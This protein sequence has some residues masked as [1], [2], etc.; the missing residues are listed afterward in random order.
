MAV[1]PLLGPVMGGQNTRP[2]QAIPMVLLFGGLALALVWLG[3]GSMLARRWARALNLVLSWLW[4]IVG[5][6]SL[7]FVALFARQFQQAIGQGQKVPAEVLLVVQL[8][9]GATLGCVYFV[10]PLAMVLFYGG[11][12]VRATCEFKDPRP[13]WTD[14][15]PLPVLAV[16][17]VL[18]AWA[19]SMSWAIP[20]HAM[21]PLFGHLLTGVAGLSAIL[22]MM[23]LLGLLAWAT[24]RLKRWAWWAV[25]GV[26]VFMTVSGA[27]TSPARA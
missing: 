15:C 23:C 19:A 6:L 7:I 11:R 24:Y 5:I 22:A 1:M 26:M 14:R 9:M 17:V 25:L 21:F 18:V 12:H 8:V 16:S 4:L 13:R 27:V 3:V 2:A 10:L 20:Y